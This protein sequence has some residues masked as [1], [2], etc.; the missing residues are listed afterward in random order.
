MKKIGLL[1]TALLFSMG[2]AWA[3]GGRERENITP[4]DMANRQTQMMKDSLQLDEKQATK[5][6]AINLEYAKKILKVRDS[7]LERAEK[8]QEIQV[9][10]TNKEYEIKKCLT[11]EQA[12][13]YQKMVEAMRA[14]RQ[15]RMKPKGKE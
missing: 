3:Q 5:V 8:M 9:L 10:N 2:I 12:K 7:E 6:A 15:E 13:R 14:K 4:E 11:K 1:F